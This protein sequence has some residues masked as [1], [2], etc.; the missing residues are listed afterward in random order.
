MNK[1]YINISPVGDGSFAIAIEGFM[2]GEAI[3]QRSDAEFVLE[4][5]SGALASINDSNTVRVDLRITI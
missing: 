1:D 4:W 3:S 2:V 5:L